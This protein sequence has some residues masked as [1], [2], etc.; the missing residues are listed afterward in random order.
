MKDTF[1]VMP[2]LKENPLFSCLDETTLELLIRHPDCR[3]VGY[4]AGETICS[5]TE[6]QKAIGILIKGSATVHRL[7]RDSHVLLTTI[8]P[9]HMF[10][11]STVFSDEDRFATRITAKSHSQV[12][13]FPAILCESL[14]HDNSD[15]AVAY[16]RFLSDRIRFL[17][18]RLAELSAPAVEQKLAKYLSERA[19]RIT[20][21]MVELAASLGIGRASLYRTLDDFIHRK[22]IAKADHDILI[23][24]PEG[25]RELI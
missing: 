13:Y 6:Y 2:I 21:N 7:G 3:Y 11:V 4:A 22:L 12:F 5:E 15:F 10:G 24:D 17:N 14:V 25:L 20:P 1:R 8:S 18:R 19:P 23:L 16:I 9:G